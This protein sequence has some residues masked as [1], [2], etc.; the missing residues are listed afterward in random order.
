MNHGVKKITWGGP[1][2]LIVSAC[3]GGMLTGDAEQGDAEER[4][5]VRVEPVVET[6]PQVCL[7]A[8]DEADE[9]I[10]IASEQS[11]LLGEQTEII[12]DITKN[13]NKAIKAAW[14][15]NDRRLD[16]LGVEAER[17]VDRV[18][19]VYETIDSLASDVEANRYWKFAREC[20]SLAE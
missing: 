10:E 16:A 17:I 9:L 12:G 2:L 14:A 7:D 20:R 3:G 11:F 8:L 1:L 4:E 15:R 5:T 6:V 13:A 19:I 18:E